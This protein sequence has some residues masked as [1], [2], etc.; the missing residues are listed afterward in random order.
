MSIMSANPYT[1]FICDDLTVSYDAHLFPVRSQT[2]T[3]FLR[4]WGCFLPG[5]EKWKGLNMALMWFNRIIG[6]QSKGHGQHLSSRTTH[7]FFSLL[8][9]I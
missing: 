6:S 7:L 4:F 9:L 5:E 8:S 2:Q 3:F 1:Q